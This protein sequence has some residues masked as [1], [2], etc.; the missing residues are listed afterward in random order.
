MS[1]LGEYIDNFVEIDGNRISLEFVKKPWIRN[2]YLKFD[3]DRL[4]VVSRNE[5]MMQKIVSKHR[6]WISKHYRQIKNTV[7]L[8]DS[9]SVFYN[10]KRY[11]VGYVKSDSRPKADIWGDNLIIYAQSHESAERFIDRTIRDDTA[12]FS[13]ELAL[14]KAEQIDERFKEIKVRRYRKWG[15]CRSDRTITFNYCVSMLP[16]E[17]QDYIVSH[18]VAHL[19]EMNHSGKFWEVVSFL[20][21]DYRRLRKE[22]K[23]YDSRRRSVY[24]VREENSI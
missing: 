11:T 6:P 20:C 10:S 12:R 2:S 8:F 17:L 21:Q 22:L 19:K 9:N 15:V 24:Q 3:E 1:R 14:R 23:N 16:K 7:K 5:M 4:V 18:E 13:G